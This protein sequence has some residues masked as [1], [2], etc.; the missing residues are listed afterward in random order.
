MDANDLLLHQLGVALC[1]LFWLL[2]ATVFVSG[3]G[4]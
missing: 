2:A 3:F 4:G 1:V